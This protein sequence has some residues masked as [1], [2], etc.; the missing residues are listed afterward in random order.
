MSYKFITPPELAERW[1]LTEDTLNQW[2]HKRIGPN[3]VKIGPSKTSRVCYRVEDIE[4]YES[5]N[6][7]KCEQVSNE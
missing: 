7:Y 5:K 1:G 3:Y 4:A 6:V 2:R